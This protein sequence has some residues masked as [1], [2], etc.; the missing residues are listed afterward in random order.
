EDVLGE[1]TWSV[2]TLLPS[3]SIDAS[4]VSV[5]TLRHLRRLSALPPPSKDEEAEMLETLKSQLHFV[6]EIRKVD[7]A[8]VAPLRSIRDETCDEMDEISLGDM[9]DALAAEEVIGRHHK[10]IRR[11][12]GTSTERQISRHWR[13]V[14]LTER[15]VGSYFVVESNKMD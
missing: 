4:L 7:A 13:P 1:P 3:S 6:N 10:R 9:S 11:K 15:K 14:D 5:K 12:L 8:G 2:R